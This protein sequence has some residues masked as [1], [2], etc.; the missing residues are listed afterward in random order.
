M[1]ECGCECYKE[2]NARRFNDQKVIF[3]FQLNDK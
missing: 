1:G 3:N 2:L